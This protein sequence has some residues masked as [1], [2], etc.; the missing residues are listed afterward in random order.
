MKTSSRR[1][2]SRAPGYPDRILHFG[3][4]DV[5]DRRCR[6]GAR[7]DSSWHDHATEE[8]FN[9]LRSTTRPGYCSLQVRQRAD[10]G[11]AGGFGKGGVPGG[12][13][14]L[15]ARGEPEVGGVGGAGD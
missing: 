15:E 14:L 1:D 11:N 9:R 13:G 10:P 6:S 12:Y 5:G 3:L 2:H 7:G 8:L 4:T